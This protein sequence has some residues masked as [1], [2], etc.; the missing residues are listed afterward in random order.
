M[1]SERLNAILDFV[2][3]PKIFSDDEIEWILTTKIE[4]NNIMM[5]SIMRKEDK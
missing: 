3:E 5:S 4:V 2:T 1:V